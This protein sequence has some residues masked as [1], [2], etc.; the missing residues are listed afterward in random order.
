MTE[1][2]SP[3]APLISPLSSSHSINSSLGEDIQCSESLPAEIDNAKLNDSVSEQLPVIPPCGAE[4]FSWKGFK[5]AG[6]NL[7][8]NVAISHQT[9]SLH[10]FCNPVLYL[11]G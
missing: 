3:I 2:S 6:D 1:H 7:D 9:K 4:T 11:I 8:K 10:V 5:L